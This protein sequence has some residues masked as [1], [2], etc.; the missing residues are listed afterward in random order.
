M[1]KEWMYKNL[2]SLGFTEI[3]AKV[4][5]FL[6]TEGPRKAREIAGA[7]NIHRRQLYYILKGLKSKGVVCASFEYPAHFSAVLLERVLDILI[8]EQEK[9]Q[10]NLEASK[11]ELL[12]IWR[13]ITKKTSEN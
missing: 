6:A 10:Q 3:E 8:V 5:V 2:V 11:N 13:Y 7:L 12:S 9:Q 1:S 4:Y